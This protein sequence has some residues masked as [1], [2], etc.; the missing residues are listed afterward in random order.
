MRKSS[1]S[2]KNGRSV[3]HH[4]R[5]VK[6]YDNIKLVSDTSAD[7]LPIISADPYSKSAKRFG[8]AGALVTGAMVSS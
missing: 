6:E 5:E 7:V 8:V 3:H 1:G 2:R 4:E